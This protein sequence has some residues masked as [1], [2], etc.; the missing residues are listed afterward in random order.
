MTTALYV[1]D[2][3]AEPGMCVIHF[4]TMDIVGE[5]LTDVDVH[6]RRADVE[7]PVAVNDTLV[8]F[9]PERYTTGQDG[10][11]SE[12]FVQGIVVRVGSIILGRPITIDTTG[13]TDVDVATLI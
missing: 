13:K 3:P 6:V 11:F 5:I 2:P 10:R 4:D 12:S 1:F 9:G 7:G 8:G